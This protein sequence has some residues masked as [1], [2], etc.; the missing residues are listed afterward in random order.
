M[1]GSSLIVGID[2]AGYGPVLGPLV[3]SATIFEADADR[4]HT[5]LWEALSEVPVRK[6]GK[7]AGEG[8]VVGDSKQ[9]YST[10]KGLAALEAGVLTFAAVAPDPAPASLED[11]LTAFGWPGL[12]VPSECP[13]YFATSVPLPVESQ[14]LHYVAALGAAMERAGLRFHGFLTRPVFVPEFNRQVEKL[15]NKSH[16]LFAVSSSL[17]EEA[18]R[19]FPDIDEGLFLYDKQGGRNAYGPLLL[20][21][22]P[23]YGFLVEYESRAESSYQLLSK[24]RRHTHRFT[25][26]GDDKHFP[27]ALASMCSKYIRELFMREFNSFWLQHRPDLRPT[28][29]YY[30]D[31]QRFLAETEELRRA[32]GIEDGTLIRSR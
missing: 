11:F 1:S 18:G 12:E 27:I 31:A 10:G 3:V 19:R 32:L 17:A 21:R 9:V 7:G 4:P 30:T 8:L 24:G 20:P 14:D 6:P 15:D 16:L 13:W 5:D 29:G 22:F 28:A 23:D 25:M 26:K 2:E